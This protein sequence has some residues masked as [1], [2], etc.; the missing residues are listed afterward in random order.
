[1]ITQHSFTCGLVLGMALAWSAC[2]RDVRTLDERVRDALLDRL[3]QYDVHGASVAVVLPDDSVHSICAGVSHDGAAMEPGMLFAIG[4]ITKNQVAA[5]ILQLAEEGAL[6]LEDPIQKWLPPLSNVDGAITIR[7]M[8]GHTSG[9]FMFWEN[10]KLWEDLIKYRDSVFAPEV[11]LTYLK[12]PHFAPG[13]GFRYS[14]TNYLLLAMIATRATHSTLSGELRKRFWAPLGLTNTYL[15]MEEEIPQ[16][17][18]AHVWGDNFEN[19]RSKRDITFLPRA[20]HESIT[21]GSAGVF[22]TAEDLALW[23]KSLF[24]GK[25]L[26]PNSLVQMLTFNPAA[27]SSWCEA[28]GLGVFQFKRGITNGEAAYGHGGGNIGTSAYMVYLPNFQTS[29]VVMINSMHGKCPDRMLEDVI[30]IVTD[31][32]E[33]KQLPA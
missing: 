14:N 10:Q 19:N 20:S 5:L 22:T 30:E 2:S 26:K 15:S 23:C 13:K 9:I 28:Y 4:S 17:R 32:L 27:A 1:M 31:H 33:G 8:L 7:Q 11:V 21:Y 18:L 25:V 6:S 16:D 12:E 3:Q 24:G 29:I